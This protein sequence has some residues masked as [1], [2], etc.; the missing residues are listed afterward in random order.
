MR[1]PVSPGSAANTLKVTE[2]SNLCE[3]E[4]MSQSTKEGE[5]NAKCEESALV[6]EKA[7]G[8]SVGVVPPNCSRHSFPVVSFE[9]LST[10]F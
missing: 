2:S 9:S 7:S 1:T 5:V 10:D 8:I 4:I 6:C 3:R